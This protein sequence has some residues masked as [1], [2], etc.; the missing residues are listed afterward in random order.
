MTYRSRCATRQTR[1]Q[2]RVAGERA[3]QRLW[4]GWLRQEFASLWRSIRTSHPIPPK[5]APPMLPGPVPRGRQ[6][7]RARYK[8]WR[9]VPP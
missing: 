4:I 8:V 5:P 6:L 2:E 1:V 3:Y 9:D 7:R